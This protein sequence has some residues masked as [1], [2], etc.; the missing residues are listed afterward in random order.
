MEALRKMTV[1][2]A[3]HLETRVPEM[4][5]KGRIALGADAD[6]TIFN[7]DTII[8]RSTFRQPSVPSAGIEFVLVNGVIVVD[9]G[10]LRPLA[11]PGRE[12][13]APAS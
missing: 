2:P 3:Q 5:N 4:K 8:D 12:V 7:P 1:M 11:F 6:V 10:K 13:R 9:Q